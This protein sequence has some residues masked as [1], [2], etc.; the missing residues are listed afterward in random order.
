MPSYKITYTPGYG[1]KALGSV[2]QEN[3]KGTGPKRWIWARASWEMRLSAESPN[4]AIREALNQ[5]FFQ[6]K[7][8]DP[9]IWDMCT[10]LGRL[11]EIGGKEGL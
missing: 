2:A 4:Q 6:F 3:L 1:G 7:E 10:V 8:R 11:W 9:L 5:G